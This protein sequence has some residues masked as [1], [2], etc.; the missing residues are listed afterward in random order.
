MLQHS[1][2]SPFQPVSPHPSSPLPWAAST[3]RSSLALHESQE[4]ALCPENLGPAVPKFGAVSLG[5]ELDLLSLSTT[6]ALS[7]TAPRFVQQ[8]EEKG[9]RNPPLAFTGL[10]ATG[11]QQSSMGER[12]AAGG[13][14]R[15]AA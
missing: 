8:K 9:G 6:V 7:S 3:G 14:M 13:W 1:V 4:Q 2:T 10:A 5:V 15:T 12:R 11:S